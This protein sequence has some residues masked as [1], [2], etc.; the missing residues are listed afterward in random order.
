M[1]ESSHRPSPRIPPLCS[2]WKVV[3]GG[4][5]NQGALAY[6]PAVRK[7]ECIGGELA[8][9]EVVHGQWRRVPRSR[10]WA[11]GVAPARGDPPPGEL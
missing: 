2:S 1:T 9:G 4:V 5:E 6:S 8:E 11:A 7:L 3:E 10:Q